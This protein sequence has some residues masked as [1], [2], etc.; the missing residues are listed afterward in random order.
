MQTF[1]TE[2]LENT[3]YNNNDSGVIINGDIG[4]VVTTLQSG[5]VVQIEGKTFINGDVD[6]DTGHQLSAPTL[7]DN[8]LSI[9]Q[10]NVTGVSQ[11][12]SV[13]IST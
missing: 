13:V 6:L 5:Y 8:T 1:W 2:T 7:T 4:S 10:G 3:I 11:E 9:N 12:T